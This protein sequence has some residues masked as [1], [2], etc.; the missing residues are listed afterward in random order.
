MGSGGAGDV[1]GLLRKLR[2]VMRV[3]LKRTETLFRAWDSNKSF[4]IG[5]KE[6]E[7]ALA[8]MG[9]SSCKELTQALFDELDD[10]GSFYIGFNEFKAWL[11]SSDEEFERKLLD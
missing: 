7:A 2:T 8:G 9:F 11:F 4:S 1:H 3:D 5:F 6:F 10:D